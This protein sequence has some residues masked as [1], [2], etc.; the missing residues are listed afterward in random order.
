MHDWSEIDHEWWSDV[1]Y[2]DH[3][4]DSNDSDIGIAIINHSMESNNP[5]E[6]NQ[7]MRTNDDEM[8]DEWSLIYALV[9]LWA[10]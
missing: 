10:I 8:N 6:T 1:N 3:V 9:E 7:T 4:H 2:N 5:W